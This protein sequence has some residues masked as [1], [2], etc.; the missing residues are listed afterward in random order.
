M[1]DRWRRRRHAIQSRRAHPAD[2]LHS[3]SATPRRRHHL[4]RAYPPGS[5]CPGVQRDQ[6]R[7]RDGTGSTRRRPH[8]D[9]VVGRTIARPRAIS[10]LVSVFALVGLIL[11]AVGVYGVM[12]YSVKER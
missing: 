2:D 10:V 11:A 1:D 8:A 5:A 3:H 12:A 6:R 4:L 9:D 7:A